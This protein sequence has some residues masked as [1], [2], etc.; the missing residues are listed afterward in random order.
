MLETK[1]SQLPSQ[2]S[3]LLK[4]P[5]LNQKLPLLKKFL[6]LSQPL[7][8]KYRLVLLLKNKL[9]LKLLKKNPLL[10]HSQR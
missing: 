5:S 9:N 4:S 8:K 10:N 1:H 6:K 7:L 3:N 2:L